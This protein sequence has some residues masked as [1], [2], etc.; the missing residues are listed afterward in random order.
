MSTLTEARA[1]RRWHTNVAMAHVVDTVGDHAGRVVSWLR[2]NAPDSVLSAEL[3]H[4]AECHDDGEWLTGDIPPAA[5]LEMPPAVREWW[6]AQERVGRVVV[7]GHDPLEGLSRMEE[8]WL[9]LADK[10]D[11]YLTVQRH[12][13]D[14]L[15]KSEWQEA[16]ASITHRAYVLNATKTVERTLADG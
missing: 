5:K 16:R 9:A 1:V 8:Q 11:A 4:A 10:V 14:D 3:I 2:K 15:R 7:H 13:P 12:A 6:T